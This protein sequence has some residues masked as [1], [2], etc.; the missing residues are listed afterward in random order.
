[1]C[2]KRKE[3]LWE[4]KD[5]HIWGNEAKR[6]DSKRF[7]VDYGRSPRD[8]LSC[9]S[10][11][12]VWQNPEKK[13]KGIKTKGKPNHAGLAYHPNSLKRSCDRVGWKNKGQDTLQRPEK[14]S[15]KR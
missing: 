11:R 8:P 3:T 13:K 6:V 7:W 14:K 2:P 9:M 1:M 4:R 15:E 5:V 10:N 12:T